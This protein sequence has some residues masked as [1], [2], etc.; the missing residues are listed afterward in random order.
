MAL[1]DTYIS[2]DELIEYLGTP[3]S[4]NDDMIAA[5]NRAAAES[6]NMHCARDFNQTTEATARVYLADD[7]CQVDVDDFHTVT[8]LVVKTDDDNTGTYETTWTITTDFV[9]EPYD[10]VVNGRTGFPF[11]RI[12]AVGD[13]RFPPVIGRPQVQVTAQWGWAEIPASV[14]QANRIVAAEIFRL[15]DAPLGVAGVNDFGPIRVRDVP[16]AAR[17]LLPYEHPARTVAVG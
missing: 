10:G 3:G 14:K 1:G 13:R 8:D 6:I 17:L 15:K 9:L 11:W 2:D 7:Y 16:Q 4:A 12:R 5:A